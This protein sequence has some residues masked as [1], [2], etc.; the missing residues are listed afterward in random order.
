MK[1]SILCTDPN[2]PV[3][4]NLR[5]WTDEVSRKGHDVSL[6][7]DKAELQGGD[8]LFLVSCS[9]L[10][11]DAEREKYKATLVLHASDLPKG[12]GWSPYIWSILGGANIITVS[13]LEASDPVDSGAIW[14]KTTFALEGHEL[15][16]EIN[17]KLFAAETRL[18]TQAIERFESIEPVRQEGDPGPYMTKRSP[19]DSKLDPYRT[20]A[21][22]FNL[23][24]VVD[25]KRY[26][27]FF[28]YQGMRYLIKIEKVENE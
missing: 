18:M 26:P 21:E 25:S 6:V 22:Q 28:D 17:A 7:F 4:N 23:L 24:R 8:I 10:I 1:I 15:L 12:R 14:L 3:V 9:Q 5:E 27:A 13:L 2:H 11:R 16:P 20:I 19:A